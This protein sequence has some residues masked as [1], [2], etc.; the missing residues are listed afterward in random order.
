MTI[1]QEDILKAAQAMTKEERLK[2]IAAITALPEVA[3]EPA[4]SHAGD[5]ASIAD[6]EVRELTGQFSDRHKTLLR[7]LAQ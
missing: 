7:R 3:A 6:D 4:E 1:S 5:S 2:L